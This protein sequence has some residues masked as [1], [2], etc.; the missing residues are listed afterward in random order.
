M[1]GKVNKNPEPNSNVIQILDILDKK[2]LKIATV[3]H[4][5]VLTKKVGNM[6]DQIGNISRKMDT[7]RKNKMEMFQRAEL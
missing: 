6:Q 1:S 7:T 4:L 2:V 5:K 3:K